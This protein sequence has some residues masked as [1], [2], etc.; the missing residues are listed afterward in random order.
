M[1][2]HSLSIYIYIYS[3]K[4]CNEWKTIF[5]RHATTLQAVHKQVLV[6]MC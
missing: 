4:A 3:T 5:V 6:S 1:N 2:M